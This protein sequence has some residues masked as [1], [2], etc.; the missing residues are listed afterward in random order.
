MKRSVRQ[1]EGKKAERRR[2]RAGRTLHPPNSSDLTN[3]LGAPITLLTDFGNTDYFVG[4]MKGTILSVNPRAIVVDITHSIPAHDIEA[5]AFNLLS[6]Y[7]A[8]PAGTVHVAVVDPGVGSERRPILVHAGDYM[9][10]GPDNGIFSYVYDLEPDCRIFQITSA[11]YFR[12]PVSATFHGR[13]IFAPVAAEVLGGL[14]PRRLGKLIRDPVRLKPL[15]AGP[16]KNGKLRGR[17]IHID[18]FGN[19]ITNITRTDF[20]GASRLEVAGKTIKSFQNFYA[21]AGKHRLMGVWGSAGFLEIVANQASA[22]KLLHIQRGQPALLVA[23][24]DGP[25]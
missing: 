13:D 15:Q 22:S 11:Q 21:A 3:K 24:K 16:W 4:A 20:Q 17:V 7:R 2:R 8:F 12:Q 10:V 6:C 1:G 5:A 14:T 19:C 18:H 25:S 23:R 9:F